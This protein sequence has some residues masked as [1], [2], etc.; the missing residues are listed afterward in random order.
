V[1][2]GGAIKSEQIGLC[3]CSFVAPP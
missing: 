3:G 2:L 1:T